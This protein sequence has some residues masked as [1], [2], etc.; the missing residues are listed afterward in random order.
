MEISEL[1]AVMNTVEED[2]RQ[3][4]EN[5]QALK[6]TLRSLTGT[7]RSP[8]PV[9]VRLNEETN[10]FTKRFAEHTRE[11]EKTLFPFLAEHLPDEPNLVGGLRQQHDAISRKREEFRDCLAM[12]QEL[13]DGLSRAVLLDVLASG[14]ELLDLLDEHAREETKAVQK[15]FSRYL[16]TVP[17]M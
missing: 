15:C 12:A 2:H 6:E 13:G 5:L 9:L 11:E 10:R 17:G 8:C 16:Q 1:M 4:L 3:V 7:E 14:W